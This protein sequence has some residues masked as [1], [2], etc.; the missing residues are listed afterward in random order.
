MKY[1]EN[2][3]AELEDS[4]VFCEE[5]GAKVETVPQEKAVD[6]EQSKEAEKQDNAEIDDAVIDISDKPVGKR[7]RMIPILCGV[8]GVLIIVV[9][10]II[11]VTVTS[12]KSNNDDN[13]AEN[14][15]ETVVATESADETVKSTEATTQANNWKKQYIEYLKNVDSKNYG[16][17]EYIYMN[18]DDIPELMIL[19]NNT[20][21]GNILVTSDNTTIDSKIIASGKMYYAEKSNEL[22]IESGR[23]GVH[24]YTI[25]KIS[26]GK[27]QEE[28]VNSHDTSGKTAFVY[29]RPKTIQQIIDDLSGET[30]NTTTETLSAASTTKKAIE[31]SWTSYTGNDPSMEY[32][33]KY[34]LVFNSDG[35]VS[36]KGY[37]NN[38]SGNYEV[39]SDG[40][41]VCSFTKCI[42]SFPPNGPTEIQGYTA[43]FVL[44]S[45]GTLTS[46]TGSNGTTNW[47]KNTIWTKVE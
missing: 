40:T 27:I 8:I 25:Y 24:A 13:N 32:S 11:I 22:Y 28:E 42:D 10:V 45:D 18:N 26:D 9:I 20:A 37:K 30:A 23:Q 19:G 15:L 41:I 44:N 34:T 21:A 46:P 17:C 4:A 2:C 6:S 14:D 3:G 47:G 5:C 31:G 1:C 16:G 7:K 36:C 35:T 12:R 29:N 33:S 38:H 39:E 43:K